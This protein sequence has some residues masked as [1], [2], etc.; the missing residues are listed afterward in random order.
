MRRP[1]AGGRDRLPAVQAAIR[2]CLRWSFDRDSAL[3]CI[4]ARRQDL[5][6][7]ASIYAAPSLWSLRGRCLATLPPLR[8][9]RHPW[10][11]L[12]DFC[13]PGVRFLQ[14]FVE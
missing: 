2:H 3:R 13:H 14:S 1:L 9:L 11:A 7:L 4:S 10:G 5:A 6:I 12:R 8:P